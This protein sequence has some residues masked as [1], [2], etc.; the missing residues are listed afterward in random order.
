M[1]INI[2]KDDSDINIVKSWLV[3]STEGAPYSIKDRYLKYIA[4]PQIVD[5]TFT[6]YP[7]KKPVYRYDFREIAEKWDG[8]VGCKHD[9]SVDDPELETVAGR[10][11][12][13]LKEFIG[14]INKHPERY[15]EEIKNNDHLEYY[16]TKQI[17]RITVASCDG[18][19]YSSAEKCWKDM[20]EYAMK[21]VCTTSE[22]IKPMSGNSRVSF[23]VKFDEENKVV[24]EQ[25]TNKE[26]IERVVY[27]VK[28]K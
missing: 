26:L 10:I 1:K 16:W 9:Y 3:G 12:K 19:T 27:T 5:F 18:V 22:I 6:K 8:I 20:M 28:V 11:D 23:A 7:S 25:Y 14:D 17:G 15:F 4:N 21:E 2:F 24:V 13:E